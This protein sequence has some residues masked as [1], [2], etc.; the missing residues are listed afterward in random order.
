MHHERRA[1]R[2]RAREARVAPGGT[3][4]GSVACQLARSATCSQI[5]AAT[6]TVCTGSGAAG[7]APS[8][9]STGTLTVTTA[10]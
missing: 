1:R 4:A 9:K 10:R 6:S 3:V 5:R 8:G 7:A 2:V